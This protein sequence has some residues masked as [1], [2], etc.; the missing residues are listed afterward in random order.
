M[1]SVVVLCRPTEG[2]WEGSRVR[3]FKGN[4]RGN[5]R[6]PR[7]VVSLPYL[8]SKAQSLK[9]DGRGHSPS[10]TPPLAGCG[11]YGLRSRVPR[12]RDGTPLPPHASSEVRQLQ[13]STPNKFVW[14]VH[15][16]RSANACST[17]RAKKLSTLQAL[18]RSAPVSPAH[19]R[20]ALVAG[21][22][23]GEEQAGKFS[24]LKTPPV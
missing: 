20:F 5:N 3:G 7:A 21:C 10:P 24:Y 22:V 9:P 4:S 17:C 14:K 15:S 6:A 13:T 19:E 2:G 16:T 23:E 18:P 8:K 12:D 1:A 11:T